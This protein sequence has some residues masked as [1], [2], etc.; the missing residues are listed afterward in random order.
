MAFRGGPFYMYTYTHTHTHTH[1]H[2]QEWYF[3]ADPFED[4]HGWQDLSPE[5]WTPR[6]EYGGNRIPIRV[7]VC[8]M[9]AHAHSQQLWRI[10]HNPVLMSPHVQVSG[11][12]F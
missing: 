1:T 2:T 6:F 10:R 5:E 12:R 7:Q 9:C 11:L 4:T 8:A 3:V